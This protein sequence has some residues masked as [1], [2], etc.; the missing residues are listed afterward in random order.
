MLLDIGCELVCALVCD[1][2]ARL[3]FTFVILSFRC[4]W[5]FGIVI[6]LLASA[7]RVP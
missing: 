4:C 7:F 2:A 5:C 3:V 1:I 6:V